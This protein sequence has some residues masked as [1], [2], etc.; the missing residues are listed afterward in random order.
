MLVELLLRLQMLML[1]LIQCWTLFFF[2]ADT[3]AYDT[4]VAAATA[5]V[6][7]VGIVNDVNGI[8]AIVVATDDVTDATAFGIAPV[9]VAPNTDA[10]ACDCCC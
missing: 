6:D 7:V 8:T 10:T 3:V 1:I 4:D 5:N 9:V 2:S